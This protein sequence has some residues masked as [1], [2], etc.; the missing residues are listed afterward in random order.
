[1]PEAS[2]KTVHDDQSGGTDSLTVQL[3]EAGLGEDWLVSPSSVAYHPNSTDT[4]LHIP[5]PKGCVQPPRPPPPVSHTTACRSLRDIC[6]V[7][8]PVPP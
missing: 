7:C 5:S 6:M 1:M 4:M 3:S 2:R 8:P